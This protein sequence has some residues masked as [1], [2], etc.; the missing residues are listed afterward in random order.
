MAI[1]ALTSIGESFV[2]KGLRGKGRVAEPGVHRMVGWPPPYGLAALIFRLPTVRAAARRTPWL[3]DG[4]WESG[5]R[6]RAMARS[7]VSSCLLLRPFSRHP[8]VPGWTRDWQELP[9]T[10]G[11][12]T[13]LPA[14]RPSQ[15]SPL[16]RQPQILHKTGCPLW[17]RS[18][19]LRRR[20]PIPR[21]T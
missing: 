3:L 21:K 13:D 17:A 11:I 1:S 8:A 12:V 5:R 20:P 2:N 10:F 14:S 4:S 9:Q 6:D 18:P 19:Q 15:L 16:G 7:V